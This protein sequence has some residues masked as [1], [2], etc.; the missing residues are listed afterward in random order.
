[1]KPL[2]RCNNFLPPLETLQVKRSVFMFGENCNPHLL[3]D[4]RQVAPHIWS[5]VY[6]SIHSLQSL[7]PLIVK[8]SL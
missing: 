4:S 7:L 6:S 3:Y 2:L 1:M 8:G 5:L